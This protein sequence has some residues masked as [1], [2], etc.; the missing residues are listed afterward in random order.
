MATSRLA[1][2]MPYA[3]FLVAVGGFVAWLALDAARPPTREAPPDPPDARTVAVPA[4]GDSALEAIQPGMPRLL[5]EQ[6]FAHRSSA[7]VEPVD[8]SAG[9]PVLR[10][11]YV[12]H[13]SRPVEALM[14]DLQPGEFRP[15]PHKLTL[16]FDGARPGHPLLRAE[17]APLGR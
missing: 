17:L 16:E 14:P 12:V 8:F 11:R 10:T 4:A 2:A 6:R 13:L 5:V 3:V 1:S 15:G 7:A 9:S